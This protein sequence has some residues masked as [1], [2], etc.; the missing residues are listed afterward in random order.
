VE[1]SFAKKVAI[2]TGVSSL[3]TRICNNVTFLHSTPCSHKVKEMC[4]S[5]FNY[6]LSHTFNLEHTIIYRYIYH[7]SSAFSAYILD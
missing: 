3:H 6:I 5:V 2:L 4:T 1:Q 7:A